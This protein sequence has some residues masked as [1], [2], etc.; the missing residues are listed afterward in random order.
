[1]DH[2]K[3]CLLEWIANRSGCINYLLKA[4]IN[5]L[6]YFKRKIDRLANADTN[7]AQ[8]TAGARIRQEIV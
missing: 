6:W 4:L 3:E 5:Q 7:P 2:G 1:M 8:P